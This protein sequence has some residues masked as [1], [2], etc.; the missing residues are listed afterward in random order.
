MVT[1]DMKKKPL[2][3]YQLYENP[4]EGDYN[5]DISHIYPNRPMISCKITKCLY[6]PAD[7]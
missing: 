2:R 4:V 6:I 5:F 7:N 1:V 3:P